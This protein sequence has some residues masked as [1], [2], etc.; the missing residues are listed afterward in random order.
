MKLNKRLWL[1][2]LGSVCY[3]VVFYVKAHFSFIGSKCHRRPLPLIDTP[4]H[5]AIMTQRRRLAPFLLPHTRHF[6]G[7]K[8]KYDAPRS[9]RKKRQPSRAQDRDTKIASIKRPGNTTQIATSTET[10]EM[11]EKQSKTS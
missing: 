7:S 5:C 6:T 10:D 3:V 8:S 4:Q 2:E 11:Q 9:S 1:W